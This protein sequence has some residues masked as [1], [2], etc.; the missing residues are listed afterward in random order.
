MSGLPVKA[1]TGTPVS[2]S[3]LFRLTGS[4]PRHRLGLS[5]PG[6]LENRA[7]NWL[8]ARRGGTTGVDEPPIRDSRSPLFPRGRWQALRDHRRRPARLETTPLAPSTHRRWLRFG[9]PVVGT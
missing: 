4:G 5:V 8:K 9:P 7:R 1:A 6:A 3:Y 2:Q